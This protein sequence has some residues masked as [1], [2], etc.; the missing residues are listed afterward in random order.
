MGEAFE[1]LVALAIAYQAWLIYLIINDF[2][3]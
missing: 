1:V 3:E 2:Q